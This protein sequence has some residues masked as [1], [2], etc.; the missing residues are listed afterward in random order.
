VSERASSPV[1]PPRQ[2]QAPGARVPTSAQVLA[3]RRTPGEA[4]LAAELAKERAEA[5]GRAGRRLDDALAEH[6]RAHADAL[7][8]P[9][10]RV[11]R[12]E[13]DR[14]LGAIASAVYALMVQR[15]CLGFRRDNLRWIRRS[16]DLPP[17]VLRRL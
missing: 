1:P 17:A 14:L 12:D 5:A 8:S 7:A 2:G 15:E 4:A 13:E 9:H 16:Y 3:G 6:A 11:A 10:G